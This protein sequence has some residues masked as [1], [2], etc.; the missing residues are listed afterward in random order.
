M[1]HVLCMAFVHGKRKVKIMC[2]NT[3]WKLCK[4]MLL[5]HGET[6]FGRATYDILPWVMIYFE[7][8]AHCKIKLAI[9]LKGQSCKLHKQIYITASTQRTNIEIFAFVVC[10]VFKLFSR[11]GLRGE[12]RNG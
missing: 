12:N 2:D 1:K 9:S 11:K 3:E 4:K 8:L 6:L 5:Y 10:L 7:H